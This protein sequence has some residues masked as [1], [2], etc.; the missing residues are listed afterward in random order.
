M[1]TA[2]LLRDGACKLEGEEQE[3]S[4]AQTVLLAH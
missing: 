3:E 1:T 2:S 4:A